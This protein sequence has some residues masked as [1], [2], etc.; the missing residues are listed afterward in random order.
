[1]KPLDYKKCTA[2]YWKERIKKYPLS[3]WSN[4]PRLFTDKELK[5]KAIRWKKEILKNGWDEWQSRWKIMNLFYLADAWILLGFI[6]PKNKKGFFD[7]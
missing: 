1:M 2:D 5:I 3:E 7:V 4:P 6:F